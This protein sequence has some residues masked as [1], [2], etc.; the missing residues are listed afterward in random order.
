MRQEVAEAN[1]Q[2]EEYKVEREQLVGSAQVADEGLRQQLVDATERIAELG[3]ERQNLIDQLAYAQESSS[4]LEMLRQEVSEAQAK[5]AH[6]EAERQRH[7][8]RID[9]LE[10]GNERFMEAKEKQDQ[11]LEM[12]R[13]Y[14]SEI[15][16]QH[17][18]QVR[19]K[20][21]LIIVFEDTIFCG[22]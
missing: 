15:K 13:S 9:S 1:R 3:A 8:E 21:K 5:I 10:V 19:N 11:E 14:H 2:L 18:A 12:L 17:D 7:L 16:N 20:Y 22:T 6:L 4:S